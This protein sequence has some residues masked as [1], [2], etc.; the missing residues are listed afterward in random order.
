MTDI[1]RAVTHRQ[2]ACPTAAQSFDSEAVPQL[3]NKLHLEFVSEQGNG[4]DVV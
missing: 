1:P 4:A 2:S 3:R